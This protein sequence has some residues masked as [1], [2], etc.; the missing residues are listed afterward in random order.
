MSGVENKLI[1]KGKSTYSKTLDYLGKDI[2]VYQT[3][4]ESPKYKVKFKT[5][6]IIY[7]NQNNSSELDIFL[8]TIKV[9]NLFWCD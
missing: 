4:N 8:S 2:V 6:E 3:D 9:D 7:V 5:G 1:A